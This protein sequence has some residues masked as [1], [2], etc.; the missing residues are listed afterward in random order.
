MARIDIKS[1]EE[2]IAKI[3]SQIE[4]LEARKKKLQEKIYNTITC[5]KCNW[6]WDQVYLLKVVTRIKHMPKVVRISKIA[7]AKCPLCNENFETL[8]WYGDVNC[9]LQEKETIEQEGKEG[10]LYPVKKL[11]DEWCLKG[12]A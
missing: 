7:I 3:D 4:K 1:F 5:P 2:G 6:A 9:W 10:E 8:L 11:K 12:D